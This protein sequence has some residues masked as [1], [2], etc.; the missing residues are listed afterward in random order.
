MSNCLEVDVH[1]GGNRA[2]TVEIECL[3]H[4]VNVE[5]WPALCKFPI[6]FSAMKFKL[7]DNFS[8]FINIFKIGTFECSSNWN[9]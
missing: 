2:P 7:R 5:M 6:L 4:H 3:I 8:Q 1:T 9:C